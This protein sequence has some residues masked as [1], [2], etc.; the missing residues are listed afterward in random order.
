[1]MVISDR[2]SSLTYINLSMRVS[3]DVDIQSLVPEPP[4][5]LQSR[6]LTSDIVEQ[7]LL[8]TRNGMCRSAIQHILCFENGDTTCPFFNKTET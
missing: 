1:M 7:K 8:F 2:L 6:L 3:K 4:A 5:V